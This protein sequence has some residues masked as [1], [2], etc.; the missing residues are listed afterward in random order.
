MLS[1]PDSFV[2]TVSDG[3]YEESLT[4]DVTVNQI[5]DL[6]TL[7]NELAN[8]EIFA[9]VAFSFTVLQVPYQSGLNAPIFQD[10]EDGLYLSLSAAQTDGSVLP[11][12]L[13]FDSDSQT[14]SG[15]PSN[16]DRGVYNIRVTGTDSFGDTITDDFSIQVLLS[17]D[18][19]EIQ[20]PISTKYGTQDTA[21]ELRLTGNKL[22]V[23]VD[24][25]NED[26]TENTVS[27][28]C[29][30]WLNCDLQADEYAFTGTPG[31]AQVG[32][33]TVT[34][35]ATDPIPMLL[36]WPTPPPTWKRRPMHSPSILQT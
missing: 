21:F 7:E 10:E 36:P 18:P 32:T 1:G 25:T 16:A 29:P 33:H 27:V 14:F 8:H 35:L 12:W 9:N 30:A 31:N 34:L 5:N 20:N 28:T 23:F 13:S 2:V 24:D 15:T 4:V 3:E 19:P 6:P 22:P 26:G 11:E 17:N